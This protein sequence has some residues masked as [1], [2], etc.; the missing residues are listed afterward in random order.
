MLKYTRTYT[1][2]KFLK[3]HDTFTIV[4]NIYLELPK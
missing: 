3:K 2:T 4:Q 1:K